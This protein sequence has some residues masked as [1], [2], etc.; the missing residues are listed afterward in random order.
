[1]RG[2]AADGN[3]GPLKL[4]F[5]RRSSKG[6]QREGAAPLAYPD[7]SQGN[8]S[9]E[10]RNDSAV[11]SVTETESESDRR[12][13]RTPGKA[14][15]L[16]AV[17]TFDLPKV[18]AAL[19]YRDAVLHAI[20]LSAA[21]LVTSA[22]L[23]EGVPKALEIVGKAMTV[24]RVLIFEYREHGSR[25]SFCYGWQVPDLPVNFR[26]DFLGRY[27]A[28]SLEVIAWMSP[29]PHQKSTSGSIQDVPGAVRE[30][31]EALGI[32]SILI[33]PI[34]VA[35]RFW[36]NIGIHSC[37]S[38]RKWAQTEI[39]VLGTLAE[40]IGSSIVRERSTKQL[41]DANAIINATPT[42]LFRL[43]AEPGFPPVSVF[44]NLKWF[45]YESSELLG[46]PDLYRHIVHPDDL[47]L[48][49]N[50]LNALQHGSGAQVIDCRTAKSGSSRWV[51]ARLNPIRDSDGTLKQIESVVFDITDRKSIEESLRSSELRFRTLSEAAQDAIIVIDT[52][53]RITFWN[54][55][56]TRIFGYSV[57][58]AL[59]H[60]LDQWLASPRYRDRLTERLDRFIAEPGNTTADKM[61]QMEALR[62]DGGE[63]PIELSLSPMQLGSDRFAI[64]I[65]RDISERK[66]AEARILSMVRFDPLTSLFNRTVFVEWVQKAVAR[67]K[68][69]GEPFAILYLDLDHFKDVNDTLGHPKGDLLLKTVA[70]RLRSSIRQ[71]DV[72]ARFGGDEFAIM[73][74]DIRR[75]ED[76]SILARKL[77]DRLSEPY[78]IDGN[79]IR[80]GASIGI[81]LCERDALDAE[82]L[83]S[84]ADVA[85]YR[86]KAE[87]RNCYQF[88]TD[89]MDAE[90][91]SRF[92]L[93]LQLRAAIENDEIFVVYQPQN[94]TATGQIIGLEALVRWQHPQRGVLRPGEFISAAEHSGLI[95]PLGRK[96]LQSACAQMKE[97]VD[98]RIAPPTVSVN[99]SAIE[100]K[101]PLELEQSIAAALADTGL[102]PHY[103]ELELTETVLME[104]SLQH[105]DVL[106]RLKQKGIRL[107]I[108]DFG[109][110]FS[111]FD[112]LRRYP[113]SRIKISQHF[114][115]DMMRDSSN[116][117]IVKAIIGLAR[118]LH[119]DFI[120][121]GVENAAQAAQLRTWGCHQVQGYYFAKPMLPSEIDSLLLR[122]TIQPLNDGD[123]VGPPALDNSAI[124]N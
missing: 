6:P 99:I 22:S 45:G 67:V 83:L 16:H 107:A 112:Y 85:L 21:A 70:Q 42:M 116:A 87:G 74:V 122:G 31:F 47:P 39:D 26:A 41:A 119:M 9:A 3:R 29:T 20:T 51:E 96:V 24:D 81:A 19:E 72:L 102:P 60:K 110:G 101:A 38:E 114:V 73:E 10:S 34:Y 61:V 106:E 88:F 64:A 59:G 117:A 86:A 23:D 30:L 105:N 92:T 89:A 7:P 66:R 35:G 50:A 111:S 52:Q 120:A 32:Q 1:M 25:V 100:F 115:N 93:A 113:V 57:E 13:G 5:H 43:S 80:L 2:P 79:L 18:S 121:E 12:T 123:S 4:F 8:F 17:E 98:A 46:H 103:L 71:T 62:R 44:G 40:M 124:E 118:E 97:W 94:D 27:P 91:R 14:P 82:A 84:Y 108:D 56:A 49:S 28:N 54:S 104:T 90:V 55:A 48:V 58:E 95:I 77:L 109:T 11:T 76:A 37:K 15:A 53:G 75:P 63:I 36:G 68:R 78:S 65:G 69:G 33:V